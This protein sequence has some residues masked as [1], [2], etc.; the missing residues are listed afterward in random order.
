MWWSLMS[1]NCCFCQHQC[2]SDGFL[3][4]KN[5]KGAYSLIKGDTV[6]LCGSLSDLKYNLSLKKGPYTWHSYSASCVFP[7]QEHGIA[8]LVNNMLSCYL[9]LAQCSGSRLDGSV[10]YVCYFVFYVST[11]ERSDSIGTHS[12]QALHY[13]LWTSVT[14]ASPHVFYTKPVRQ[15]SINALAFYFLNTGQCGHIIALMHCNILPNTKAGNLH[16]H[17]E[18]LCKGESLP[19]IK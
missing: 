14:L 18:L 2:L 5:N 17:S 3:S 19:R 4:R 15:F 8:L 6:S 12:T 1:G 7:L 16:A 13:S 10:K 9:W 11:T